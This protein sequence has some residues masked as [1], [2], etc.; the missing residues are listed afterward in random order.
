MLGDQ[1]SHVQ[2]T[3]LD[4]Q[5]FKGD[6]GITE[7]ETSAKIPKPRMGK[8]NNKNKNKNRLVLQLRSHR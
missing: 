1:W 8:N 7:S 2:K 3:K 4:T 6:S 5:R